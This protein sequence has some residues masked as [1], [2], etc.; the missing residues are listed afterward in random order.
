MD[1]SP[2]NVLMSI[3]KRDEKIPETT[4]DEVDT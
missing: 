2:L 4:E 1:A 3:N